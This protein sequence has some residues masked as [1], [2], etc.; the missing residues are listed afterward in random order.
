MLNFFGWMNL[1]IGILAAIA[2]VAVFRGVFRRSLS[3]ASAVRFLK[4]SLFAGVAGL[5][6]LSRHLAPLQQICMVSVYCSGAAIVAWLKFGL[7]GR[8]RSIF[9]LSLTS[10]LYFDI[11]SVFTQLFRTPSLSTM[12]LMQPQPFFQ[13]VQFLF[14]AAFIVLGVLAMRKFRIEPDRMSVLGKFRHT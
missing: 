3:A 7:V 4:W 1:A 9:A 11:V 10:V 14:A 13:F 12:R 8:S 5:M 6:P 2:G